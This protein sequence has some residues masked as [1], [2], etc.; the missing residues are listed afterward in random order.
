[1]GFAA[2]MILIGRALKQ[3]DSRN[4]RDLEVS[5]PRSLPFS[6]S[7]ARESRIRQLAWP[8]KANVSRQPSRNPN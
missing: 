6:E 1:L 4:T 2:S 3:T 8:E 7:S 5:I